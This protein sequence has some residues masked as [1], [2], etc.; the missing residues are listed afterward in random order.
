M[1]FERIFIGKELICHSVIQLFSS[2]RAKIYDIKRSKQHP[3][4]H[5]TYPFSSKIAPA[6]FAG[7]FSSPRPPHPFPSP[8]PPSFFFSFGIGGVLKVI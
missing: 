1:G 3:F 6:A 7:S 4:I 2:G 8:T 5:P